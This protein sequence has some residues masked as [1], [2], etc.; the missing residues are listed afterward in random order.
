MVDAHDTPAQ[1]GAEFDK[2]VEHVPAW[3]WI[4]WAPA[5]LGALARPQ[6]ARCG[7]GRPQGKAHAPCA[8]SV[9]EG[10]DGALTGAL[11]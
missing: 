5:L 9:P 6:A 3:N 1:L 11:E 7:D 10:R 8:V 4:F 2:N